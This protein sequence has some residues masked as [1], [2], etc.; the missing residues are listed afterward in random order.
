MWW[1]SFQA[2]S[3]GSSVKLFRRLATSNLE[4]RQGGQRPCFLVGFRGSGAKPYKVPPVV[5]MEDDLACSMITMK[6]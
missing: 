1:L 4:P 5:S 3:Q 2:H 6:S